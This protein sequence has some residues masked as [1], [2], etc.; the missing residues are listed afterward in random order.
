MVVPERVLVTSKETEDATSWVAALA[1][2]GEPAD[3]TT[4]KF[5][6]RAAG[7]AARSARPSAIRER[8]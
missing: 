1:M 4:V 8:R 7:A 6:A 3:A 2:G 5:W